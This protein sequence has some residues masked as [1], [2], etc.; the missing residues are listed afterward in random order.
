MFSRIKII[1]WHEELLEH[2]TYA[3]R[4]TPFLL[5]YSRYVGPYLGKLSCPASVAAS[6]LA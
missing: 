4:S 2:T 3:H 5:Y 1:N 6:D